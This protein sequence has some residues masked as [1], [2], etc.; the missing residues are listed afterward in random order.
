MI[1]IIFYL[2]F[3]PLCTMIVFF[4]SPTFQDFGKDLKRVFKFL[5]NYPWFEKLQNQDL[6]IF[7]LKLYIANILTK[8]IVFPFN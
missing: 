5:K 1:Y 6:L 7:A 3:F 8:I 2:L 4:L